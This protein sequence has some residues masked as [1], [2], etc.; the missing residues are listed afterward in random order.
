M[1]ESITIRKRIF[2]ALCGVFLGCILVV[3][4][5]SYQRQVDRLEL[6]QQDLAKS[7]SQLFTSIL[8]ADGGGLARAHVGLTRLEGLMTLFAAQRRDELL[9]QVRPLFAEMKK[10]NNITHMYFI[11]P[12]GTVFLRGH[13]PEQA[14]DKLTRATYLQAAATGRVSTGLE[15]G[16]NFFSLRCVSPVHFRGRQIGYLEVAE[17]IDHVFRLMKEINGNDVAVFLTEE[18]QKK[19]GTE[20]GTEKA[21]SL[22]L[23]DATAKELALG[24]ARSKPG[25]LQKG[26]AAPVVTM[27]NGKGRSFVMG[28]A[29]L[30]DAAGETAGVIVT[31]KDVTADRAAIWTGIAT[32]LVLFSLVLAGALCVLYLSLRRSLN[33]FGEVRTHIQNVTTEWD[34]TRRVEASTGDE[35]GTLA[36]DIN[37]MTAELAEMVCQVGTSVEELR[38]IAGSIGGASKQVVKSAEVQSENIVGTS[39]SIHEINAS[40]REVAE[41]VESL[42][43]SAEETSASV[44]EMTASLNETAGNMEELSQAAEGVSSSITEIASSIRQVGASVASLLDASTTTAA[45]IAQMDATISEVERSATGTATIS[46]QLLNDAESGK[47][48]V[49]A[50]ITGIAQIRQSARV[51][52]EVVTS[53]ASRVDNIG[54]ILSVIDDVTNQTNLLALNASI[55]AAQAGEH[56]KS[57]AVVAQ[58]IKGLAERTRNSTREIAD[59]IKGVEAET[60]RAVAAIADA[61]RNVEEGERLSRSSGE[62]LAKIV[63]G[64]KGSSEQVD[65]IARS[66][67]E[68]AKGSQLVKTAM[69][70]VSDMVEQ[71][72]SANREQA[73]SGELIAGAAERMRELTAEVML[74]TRE[75]SETG[76]QIAHSTDAID[77]MIRQIGH[78]CGE[79]AGGTGMIVEAIERIRETSSGN[80]ESA[81][82]LDESLAKLSD[83]IQALHGEISRFRV[84]S[85]TR[86]DR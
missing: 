79:Q 64:V 5:F 73:R 22:T 72:V 6:S 58:E 70:H 27:V 12:D 8:A 18:Y 14:G 20:L 1:N 56:G 71:I 28:S 34:L 52:T 82:I 74:S 75:Q 35:I 59:V 31:L 81:R 15:M 9:A 16:K 76:R 25:W 3:G 10:S 48:S 83:Q 29:P 2:F 69:E 11:N 66:M 37:L 63:D 23:L 4:L 32:N 45:S 49:D 80:L 50:T 19:K 68:Q 17:E 33:L 77:T 44:V 30:K 65:A 26:L 62:A 46:A 60:K 40:V 13:K 86:G 24:L 84:E 39:S 61:E 54:T 43:A 78:A 38:R 42:S 55:L 53:L 57:F 21:G 7:G 85:G 67:Y 51:T 41:S 36:R 47:A